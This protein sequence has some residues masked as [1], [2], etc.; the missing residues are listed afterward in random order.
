LIVFG[1]NHARNDI[2]DDDSGDNRRPGRPNA[3]PGCID[4]SLPVAIDAGQASYLRV[5]RRRSSAISSSLAAAG[6]TVLHA[7]AGD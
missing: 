5:V 6:P 7:E 4:L 3:A 2:A 1:R